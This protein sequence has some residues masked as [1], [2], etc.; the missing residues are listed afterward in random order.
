MSRVSLVIV[1]YEKLEPLQRLLRHPGT[2]P[3]HHPAAEE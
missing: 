2:T 1:F 3:I